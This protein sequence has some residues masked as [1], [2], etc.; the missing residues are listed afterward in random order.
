MGDDPFGWR[1]ATTDDFLMDDVRVFFWRPHG[2]DRTELIVGFD[3]TA[4]ELRWRTEVVVPHLTAE[5]RGFRLPRGAVEALAEFVK[6]GPSQGEVKRLEEALAHEREQVKRL[7]D[8]LATLAAKGPVILDLEGRMTLQD[9]DE[10]LR[11][12][13]RERVGEWHCTCVH[14]PTPE[15][16]H[17]H[18]PGDV[19]CSIHTKGR[20]S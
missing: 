9:R 4:S 10:L 13:R 19:P 20:A 8:E 1:A 3:E 17:A 11:S 16:P 7:T 2:P 5:F 12:F 15:D 18:L 14:S 6:P